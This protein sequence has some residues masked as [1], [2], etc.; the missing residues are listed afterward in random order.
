MS[1]GARTS[2][3]RPPAVGI[4]AV[5]STAQSSA[6]VASELEELC[7]DAVESMR[8]TIEHGTIEDRIAVFKALAPLINKLQD[9]AS[10]DDGPDAAARA[11]DL[12]LGHW[13]DIA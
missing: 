9:N 11:R 6:R 4:A 10:E 5:A 12:L 7:H 1:V 8:A 3:A 13:R 2:P